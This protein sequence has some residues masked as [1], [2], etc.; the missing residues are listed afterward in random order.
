M[1]RRNLALSL[2]F[3]L[4]GL[5]LLAQDTV[6][7]TLSVPYTF[8]KTDLNVIHNSVS[9][10]PLYEKLYQVKKQKNSVV[11]LLQI[12]DSHIQADF[13]S[14]TIRK[15]MQE[16]FGNAGRGL[17]FPGRVARTNESAT[18]YSSSNVPWEAKRIVF[19]NQPLP[20]GIGAM[21]IQT[22]QGGGTLSLKTIN[23]DKLNYAFNTV[24]LFF[25][26]DF[27]SYHVAVHDSIGQEVAY[28]G[29]YTFES[30]PNSSRVFLPYLTNKIDLE[31]K[32]STSQQKQLTL[33]GLNLEN[34]KPG[35]F[36]HSVG[37]NGAKFRHY[38]EAGYFAE[39][40]T[41]LHPDLVII[42]LGTNEAIEYPYVDPQFLTQLDTFVSRLKTAN[43]NAIFL[44]TT[45][46]DFYKKKTR[47]NPG[48]E[49]I[50][51]KLIQFAEEKGIAY[52]DL[53]TTAGGKHAADLWKANGLMQS[54]GVHFTRSGYELQGNL[55]YEALIKGYNEY[56]LFR[57]P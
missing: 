22:T 38:L 41:V 31:I 40:S 5:E 33:F 48:V 55:F 28:I 45:P 3:F 23:T 30:H 35:V 47:R 27:T 53:Y 29:P 54:D 8:I 12:G 21:T 7:Y 24:T 34:G 44:L 52:W 17:V 50:R 57:Y 43:P 6:A 9:L 42:S 1:K 10:S 39:Q 36:F 46:A 37:G 20:I 13:L 51:G 4:S 11:S 18:V 26:K 16:E 25:Q 2:L 56:V 19:T 15:L 32:Q 14:G 49:I